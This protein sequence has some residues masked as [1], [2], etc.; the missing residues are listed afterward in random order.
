MQSTNDHHHSAEQ[1]NWRNTSV[2]TCEALCQCKKVALR[3]S[4]CSNRRQCHH[5]THLT[6]NQPWLSGMLISVMEEQALIFTDTSIRRTSGSDVWQWET[7]HGS[8]LWQQGPHIPRSKTGAAHWAAN[9]PCNQ[10]AHMCDSKLAIWNQTSSKKTEYLALLCQ[11]HRSVPSISV[12][13]W[14][15]VALQ[16]AH[17][18]PTCKAPNLT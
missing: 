5:R 9:R 18:L 4:R 14:A 10:H 7:H 8:D 6:T 2:P 1:I 17:S 15:W 12:S 16:A 3:L 13:A 11:Q